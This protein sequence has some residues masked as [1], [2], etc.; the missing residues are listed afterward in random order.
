MFS[1][2]ARRSSQSTLSRIR[3]R[4]DLRNVPNNEMFSA[5]VSQGS[6]VSF[7]NSIDSW[8]LPGSR[9]I[10]SVLPDVGWSRFAST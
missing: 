8:C 1:R 10:S 6:S 4:C 2:R 5:T 9:S 3:R 7:W